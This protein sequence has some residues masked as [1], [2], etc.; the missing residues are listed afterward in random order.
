MSA[1]DLHATQLAEL[2]AVF[3][4]QGCTYHQVL[5][6]VM[7]AVAIADDAMVDQLYGNGVP[8]NEPGAYGMADENGREVKTLAEAGPCLTEACQWLIGRGLATLTKDGEDE[9]VTLREGL[10]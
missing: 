3:G 7:R 10:L 8:M 9:I 6:E 1:S 4:W 2:C 5:A